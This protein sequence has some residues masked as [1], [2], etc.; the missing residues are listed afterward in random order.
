MDLQKNSDL[1]AKSVLRYQEE[2]VLLQKQI[3]ALLAE[4]RDKSDSESFEDEKARIMNVQ[5]ALEG[6]LLKVKFKT[7]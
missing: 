3:D 4:L 2:T 7:L 5:K 6:E 1:K